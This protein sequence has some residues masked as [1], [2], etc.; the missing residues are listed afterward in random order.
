ML[1]TFLVNIEVSIVSTSLV[2]ITNSLH[3]FRETSWIVSGYLVTYTGKCLASQVCVILICRIHD[4]LVKSQRYCGPERLVRCHN[5]GI[6]CLFGGLC[7]L[8]NHHSTVRQSRVAILAKIALELS[9]VSSRA[10]VLP[11]PTHWQL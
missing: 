8:P 4:Y 3:G 1:A 6:C 10:S 5:G 9:I 2:T 11:A 7:S